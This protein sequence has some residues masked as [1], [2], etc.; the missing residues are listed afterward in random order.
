MFQGAKLLFV[1]RPVRNEFLYIGHA[2]VDG[3]MYGEL[4][5]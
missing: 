2:Y 4:A 3:V 1:V 5:P